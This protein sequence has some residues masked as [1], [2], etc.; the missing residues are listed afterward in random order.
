MAVIILLPM[1]FFITLTLGILFLLF[2]GFASL[3]ISEV[4][5]LN[6]H[7]RLEDQRFIQPALEA[8]IHNQFNSKPVQK[9]DNESG[10][11]PATEADVKLV[12]GIDISHYQG[13]LDWQK[14]SKEVLFGI[15]KATEGITFKDP[16]FDD[17][18]VRIKNANL[19]R[20]AYHF[21][22]SNDDPAE[23]AKFFW[24]RIE[25]Y[26]NQDLPLI[27]DIE[28]GGLKSNISKAELQAD[29]KTFLEELEELSGRKPMIYSNTYFANEYLT[30]KYFADYSLWLAEYTKRLTP[31]VPNT[32]KTKGWEFWQKSAS[33]EL[34]AANE[35]VDYDVFNGDSNALYTLI[36]SQS[37]Q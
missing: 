6:D 19:I 36:S 13:D 2:G 29:L 31:N 8:R 34:K 25:G 24:K 11:K 17:N 16:E 21:Y 37:N 28:R 5:M 22:L 20:G 14:I 10:K 23:Q 12:N 1:R 32:W 9:P 3:L 4:I 18:W 7:F 26:S 27:L 35:K 15:C 33:Y 30:N